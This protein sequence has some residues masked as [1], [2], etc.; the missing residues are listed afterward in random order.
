MM[1]FAILALAS[2]MLI[3]FSGWFVVGVI[4]FTVAALL[5]PTPRN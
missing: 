1:F 2:L 5:S 4:L 3:P